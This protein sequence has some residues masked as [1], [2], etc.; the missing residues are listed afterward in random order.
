MFRIATIASLLML[1]GAEA[2]EASNEAREPRAQAQHLRALSRMLSQNAPGA[3]AY[4]VDP[5]TIPPNACGK[6]FEVVNPERGEPTC[7]GDLSA[8]PTFQR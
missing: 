1:A 5:G 4:D 3:V 6:A 2:R 7:V 8:P